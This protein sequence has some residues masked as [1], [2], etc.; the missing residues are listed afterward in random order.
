MK[1][2]WLGDPTTP[3]SEEYKKTFRT[4]VTIVICNL[5]IQSTF[6]C[7]GTIRTIP[8]DTDDYT[9]YL[10]QN[11]YVDCPMWKQSLTNATSMI[12]GLYALIV[13]IKLRMR[14]RSKYNIPEKNC[15][16]CE[17]CCCIFFC[18]CCSMVQMAHQTANYDEIRPVCCNDTGLQPSWDGDIYYNNN[19]D[20]DKTTLTQA[21]IV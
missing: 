17:D 13:M 20:G 6:Y 18:T 11:D 2:T 3:P 12:S 10:I 21:I 15:T 16:G 14:I 1:M 8:T 7:P 19:N 4:V 5:L 9:S